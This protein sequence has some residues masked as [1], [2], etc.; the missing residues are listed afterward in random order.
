M[1]RII[2]LVLCFAMLC[3]LCGCGG[4]GTAPE[5]TVP[6]TTTPAASDLYAVGAEKLAALENVELVIGWN[7]K[8]TVG[9]DQFTV[10]SKQTVTELGIGTD[11]FAATVKE[12]VF[13]GT[14][15]ITAREVYLDGTAYNQV[16]TATVKAEMS[17]EEYLGRLIPAVAVDSAL[18]GSMEQ[19]ED[20]VI[21][22]TDATALEGWC[23]SPYARYLP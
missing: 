22:F 4:G 14:Q 15:T 17:A 3:A 11:A 5:T 8:M 18:Y 9:A 21:T 6:P 2:A 12:T 16:N 1:K 10:T 19:G 13:S 20:G 23:D 7:E